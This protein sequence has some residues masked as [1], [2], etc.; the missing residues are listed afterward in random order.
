MEAFKEML[1]SGH[2]VAW[3]IL[4]LGLILLIKILK[5]M[6][7]GLIVFGLIIGGFFLLGKFFPGLVAPLVDFV[8]GGW[9]GEHRPD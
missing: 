7:K 2:I 6:G 4:I 5:S 9:L 8:Q 3:V 1:F